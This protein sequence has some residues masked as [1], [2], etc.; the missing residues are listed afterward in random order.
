MAGDPPQKPAN[1]TV[2]GLAPV[3]RPTGAPGPDAPLP[4]PPPPVLDESAPPSVGAGRVVGI[5]GAGPVAPK[6][7][8]GTMVGIVS[9]VA[10]TP[11]NA[12][13][14]AGRT[15][16]GVARPGI[17]PTHERSSS[18]PPSSL[19]AAPPFV[20]PPPPPVIVDA[21]IQKDPAMRTMPMT[22]PSQGDR[23]TSPGVRSRRASLWPVLL[24][25]ALAA[26]LAI[27]IIAFMLRAKPAPAVAAEVRGEGDARELLV[28]C[29]TCSDGSALVRGDTRATFTG[30]KAKLSLRK[31]D[32]AL[33]TNR[34]AV[35][36][37][38]GKQQWPMT[39]EVA[40]P[41]LVRA[42]LSRLSTGAESFDLVFS[43]TPQVT[44][45]TIEGNDTKP[46]DGAA[47]ISVPVAV[48]SKDDERTFARTIAFDVKIG[49][50]TRAG[51]LNVSIPYASLKL[52]LPG[53]N[54]VLLSPSGGTLEVSGRTSP[55]AKVRLG[56]D[57]QLIAVAD[58]SG[59]F[60]GRAQPSTDDATTVTLQAFG[61]GLA[62]RR[63]A[64]AFS[65]AVSATKALELLRTKATTPFAKV[66]SK[67][68]DHV[69]EW[70]DVKLVVAQTGEEDGRTVAVGDARCAAVEGGPRCPGLRVLLPAS[71]M[72]P[73]PQNG[74]VI[75][76]VGVVV[77]SFPIEKGKA[78][79]TEIDA[80]VA[81]ESH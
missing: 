44:A 36:I 62:P 69:G 68:E 6:N 26:A 39:L 70:V 3:P 54:G 31:E 16:M 37:T 74:A 5:S 43:V 48:A 77:R 10:R 17:A 49:G 2:I 42:D 56:D 79:G 33:G 40:I 66:A 50:E 60:R 67:P 28:T 64:I 51:A 25:A 38:D 19:R 20:A 12:P 11:A 65:R 81:I 41:F 58:A 78:T 75:E 53:R 71:S 29:A 72:L 23:A 63:V 7:I 30:G 9:P 34:I 47:T 13:G 61:E 76:V 59:I 55:N 57:P 45:I 27:A 52:G 80:A 4:P 24:I 18:G 35:S 15:M 8:P 14:S 21:P 32:V 46:T 1:R 22:E 73:K